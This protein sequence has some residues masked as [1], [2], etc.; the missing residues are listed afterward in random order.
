MIVF[1]SISL[2][3]KDKP[4]FSNLNLSVGKNEKLLIQG[5]SGIGKTTLFRLILGFESIDSGKITINGSQVLPAHIQKIRTQIFYLSQDI[6]LKNE[7]VHTLINDL[8]IHSP[9]GLPDR[10]RLNSLLEQFEL[11]ETLLNKNTTELSGGERQRLGLVIGILL[12]RPIWLLDE[13]TA[14]LEARMKKKI[15]SYVLTRKKTMI[16]ISHDPVWADIEIPD[17]SGPIKIERW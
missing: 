17:A 11:D 6:D 5:R 8:F 12:D 7:T 1:D 13:P 10:T 9:Q 2:V 15:A 16:I 3:R 4:I 14:A